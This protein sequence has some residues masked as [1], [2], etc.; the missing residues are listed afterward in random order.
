MTSRGTYPELDDVASDGRTAVGLRL[1]PA[2]V[3]V[4]GT[5]VVHLDVHDLSGFICMAKVVRMMLMVATLNGNGD[6]DVINHYYCYRHSYPFFRYK[7]TNN[8]NSIVL[9]ESIEFLPPESVL[10]TPDTLFPA[11]EGH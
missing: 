11:N 4:L 2:Q 6:N 7:C 10:H 3:G 8:Y 5:P 9:G 1:G